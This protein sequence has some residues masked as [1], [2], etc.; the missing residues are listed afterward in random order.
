MM[1]DKK[2]TVYLVNSFGENI[3][4]EYKKRFPKSYKIYLNAVKTLVEGH[5]ECLCG[6]CIVEK[7]DSG[8]WGCCICC[9]HFYP[10]QFPQDQDYILRNKWTGNSSPIFTRG[11]Y[12]EAKVERFTNYESYCSCLIRLRDKLMTDENMNNIKNIEILYSGDGDLDVIRSLTKSV[13][14]NTCFNAEVLV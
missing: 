14:K 11:I 8:E 2:I 9:S 3:N 6:G 1:D 13:F 5:N 10:G 12:G 4:E 7:E